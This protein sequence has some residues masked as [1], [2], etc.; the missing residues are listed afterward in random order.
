MCHATQAVQF[1][2]LAPARPLGY[3]ESSPGSGPVQAIWSR[4]AT[5]V[6]RSF[7]VGLMRVSFAQKWNGGRNVAAKSGHVIKQFFRYVYHKV[8][9]AYVELFDRGY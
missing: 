6:L 1:L 5:A 8:N 3:P 4:A 2:S 7:R 9:S